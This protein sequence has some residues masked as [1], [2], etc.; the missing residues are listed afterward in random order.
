MSDCSTKRA[1]GFSLLEMVVAMALG[2][3]VLGAAVQLYSQGVAATWTVSQRAELQQDFRAASNMLTRDISL[4]GAGLSN[5]AAIALP[6]ATTP[7]Y[8]CDQSAKCYVNGASAAY[9]KQGTTPYLYGLIPGWKLGPTLNASQGATD[10]VTVVYTDSSFYLNC[11]TA[12]ITSSTVVTFTLPSPLTCTLPSGVSAPQNVNDSVVGLTAGDL[13]LFSFTP[14]VVAEVTS[15]SN[16]VVT[17]A[18]GDVLKMNSTTAASGNLKNATGAGTGTRILVITYYIDNT[19]SPP[20]LMRQV[21][22]HTPMPVA[23]NMAYLQFS[24]DLFDDATDT[25]SPDQ[26]DGGAGLTPP[27]LPNQ[28]TKINI[29]HM[30]M[31]S[32][33]KGAR[34][35]YQGVDLETSVSARNLTYSNGYPQ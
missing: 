12:T 9:P 23:E 20:R 2:T 25:P 35:G 32:T 27:L 28:I 19:I 26:A 29:K 16:T 22:G 10:V 18:T 30:A 7:V 4:A 15:V 21:S 1:R 3:V 8:G 5:G 13:V 6:A 31:D 33:L 11:Y 34:G 24:Y 14:N 17:F